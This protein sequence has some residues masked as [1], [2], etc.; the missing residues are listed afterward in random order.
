MSGWQNQVLAKMPPALRADPKKSAVLAGLGIIMLG[1]GLK[2]FVFTGATRSAS[3]AT[4]ISS[5]AVV[6]TGAA[7]TSLSVNPRRE[8]PVVGWLAEP[9]KTL[10]RNLF[11]FK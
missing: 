3:A 9:I 6:K 8:S 10:D 7:P 1:I 11:E 4:A 5:G 2:Q